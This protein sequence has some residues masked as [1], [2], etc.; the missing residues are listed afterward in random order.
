MSEMIKCSQ[1]NAP[2]RVPDHLLG[3]EVR[4]PSCQSTFT[5]SAGA[6][7]ARSP[8]SEPDQ[9]AQP[10]EAPVT[11]DLRVRERPQP[12]RREGR[13]D[14]FDD[15]DHPR[16]PRRRDHYLYGD[17]G[18]MILAF[19]IVSTVFI[20]FSCVA[21]LLCGIIPVGVV[22]VATGITAWILG[23]KDLAAIENG[24]RDPIGQGTTNAGMICGMIGTIVNGLIVLLQCGLVS[25]GIIAA[26][27]GGK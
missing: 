5:A 2:L 20:L 22:G 9:L 24:T 16:R 4:C 21:A 6:D 11:P 13:D 3:K 10:D 23:R 25:V 26:I 15:E 27:A 1:C 17:R 19:G 12:N 7:P 18:G 8:E 14:D